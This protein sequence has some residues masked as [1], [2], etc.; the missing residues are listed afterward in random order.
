MDPSALRELVAGLVRAGIELDP[1]EGPH[2]DV[3]HPGL[4][5]Y[6]GTR[7]HEGMPCWVHVLAPEP[8]PEALVRLNELDEAARE[9]QAGPSLVRP[10][11]LVP[12][13]LPVTVV[14][15]ERPVAPTTVPLAVE[16]SERPRDWEDLMFGLI[17][18]CDTLARLA[19]PEHAITPVTHGDIRVDDLYVETA[20]GQVRLGGFVRGALCRRVSEVGSEPEARPDAAALIDVLVELAAPPEDAVATCRAAVRALGG[21]PFAAAMA[22]KEALRVASEPRE[23]VVVDTD[24]QFSLY[25]PRAI[26][27]GHWHSVLAFAHKTEF[28]RDETGAVVDPVAEVEAQAHALLASENT[29]YSSVRTDSGTALGRGADLTFELWLDQGEVNP[30]RAH[31]HWQEAIH[32]VEFRVRTMTA[33]EGARLEGGLRV[34]SAHVLIGEARFAL[35]VSAA[36]ADTTLAPER[37][38][39]AEPVRRYRKIFA[40]YSHRDGDVVAAVRR[41][42]EVTGDS[43]LVDADTLRSGEE[44]SARLSELIDEADVFQLFWSENSMRS[45]HVR[46]EWEH[47][48]SLGRDHFVRPVYWEQPF[49]EDR[50]Q[51]LPPEDLLELHFSSLSPAPVTGAGSPASQTWG[52]SSTFTFCGTCG[53]QVAMDLLFCWSC[54]RQLRTVQL[55]PAPNPESPGQVPAES[56]APMWQTPPPSPA[57]PA[58]PPAAV[59][60]PSAPPAPEGYEQSR[61]RHHVMRWPMAATALAAVVVIIVVLLLVT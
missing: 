1:D 44:W 45:T 50:G 27:P 4:T 58:P 31:L 53:V 60:A 49:P 26:R 22:L 18:V 34:F 54:G 55:P 23:S 13:P 21:Q 51:G 61:P 19:S 39:E 57:Y 11:G 12:T 8:R 17:S 24:V 7:S 33:P 10:I 2:D 37:P 35:Q 38:T 48:L 52:G 47:A 28:L 56:S 32:R 16:L 43:Y 20:T 41:F 25:R 14:L 3:D 42:S 40:S 5:S 29:P 59:L 30:P 15:E 36:V 46:R 9:R 6:A